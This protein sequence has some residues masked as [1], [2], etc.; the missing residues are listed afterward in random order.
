MDVRV[1]NNVRVT[2]VPDG[3]TVVL[4]HGFGCDQH[5]WR[6]V[7][8]LLASTCRVVLFDHVG[9]GGSDLA[10]WN[11]E[12]YSGLDA[13][14]ADVVDLLV[15]LDFGPVVYVGHSVASMIGVLAASERPELFD[16]L[17]LV[18][19]SPR[20]ID[21]DDYQG[22]FTRGDID[23]LLESLDANYLGWSAAIAP[24]IMDNPDRP[25]LAAELTD[26]FCR[27]DPSCARSFARATFLSD[28]RTD[29]GR[30]V[31]P[32]LVVECEHDALAPREV[33]RFVHDNIVGSELITLN[34]SGHCPHVS[35][36]DL[37]AAAILSFVGRT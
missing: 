13:Y 1:K 23:E 21:D 32:T 34:A 35:H 28:N 4:A 24:M 14:A 18:T 11:E 31:T 15:D 30:V 17:V 33:G 9:A 8:A 3:P 16:K 5:L 20:Y 29:L 22:G 26:T 36:P 2:G 7:T 27:T 10:A 6:G 19:P 12:D 25:E 37:T